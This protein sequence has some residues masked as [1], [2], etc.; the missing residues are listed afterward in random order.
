MKKIHSFILFFV[1]LSM[2]IMLSVQCT[3]KT[4]SVEDTI[5]KYY[6]S[7]EKNNYTSTNPEM[8]AGWAGKSDTDKQYI[9]E[10]QGQIS[11]IFKQHTGLKEVKIVTNTPGSTAS[12][13]N[14]NVD[15]VCNDSY[16]E[17]VTHQMVKDGETWKIVQ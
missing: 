4:A 5:K 16:T 2:I 7:I 14:L 17:S 12:E 8:I 13:A 6:S 3:T 9:E 11:D 15:L 1:S 10:F